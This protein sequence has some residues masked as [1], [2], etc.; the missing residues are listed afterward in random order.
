MK[1]NSNLVKL[2][3]QGFNFT[4]EPNIMYG[5]N[6]NVS[7]LEIDEKVASDMVKQYIKFK[8]PKRTWKLWIQSYDFILNPAVEIFISTKSGGEVETI[9]HTTI[10]EFCK[11]LMVHE[12]YAVQSELGTPLKFKTKKITVYNR[13]PFGSLSELARTEIKSDRLVFGTDI[14]GSL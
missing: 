12:T 1:R 5:P 8:Y 13:P 14:S 4:I 11:S 7:R 3:Y 9:I 6:G 10:L 2:K